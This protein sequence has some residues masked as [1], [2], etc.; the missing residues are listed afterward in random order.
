MGRLRERPHLTLALRTA[1]AWGMTPSRFF[2]LPSNDRLAMVALE[3]I[4]SDKCGG[5]GHPLSETTDPE[6]VT[7]YRGKAVTCHGCV[8][9][10]KAREKAKRDGQVVFVEKVWDHR[11]DTALVDDLDDDFM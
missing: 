4:E 5:C 8:A 1:K 6:A 10:G 3:Q 7:D 2:D 9:L 11:T